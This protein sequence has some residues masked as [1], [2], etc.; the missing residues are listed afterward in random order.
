VEIPSHLQGIK[1][2]ELVDRDGGWKWHMLQDWLPTNIQHK[3]AAILPPHIENGC[4]QRCSVGGINNGF[5]IKIMYKNLCGLHKEDADPTWSKMWKL[6]V[7]ERVKTFMW[8][9]IHN[10]IL[11]NEFKARMG[12]G[13]AV[14]SYCSSTA[15][16]MIHVLRDC[17]VAM[18]FWNNIVPLNQ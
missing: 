14:C 9:I 6:L 11:T 10:R 4:D 18:E 2:K 5:S 8:L 13:N 1:V 7:P 3:I 17:S 16:T 12:L 15:E